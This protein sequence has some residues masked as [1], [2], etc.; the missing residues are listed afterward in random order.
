MVSSS[1]SSINKKKRKKGT[2]VKIL[3]QTA[4][5]WVALRGVLTSFGEIAI[6]HQMWTRLALEDSDRSKVWN[7]LLYYQTSVTNPIR[8]EKVAISMPV[9][10]AKCPAGETSNLW[11]LLVTMTRRAN[12][13]QPRGQVGGWGGGGIWL[14]AIKWRLMRARDGTSKFQ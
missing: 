14:V 10:E 4:R 12:Q 6:V 7:N 9:S 8:F 13:N 2:R 1:I 11:K 5:E 3:Y